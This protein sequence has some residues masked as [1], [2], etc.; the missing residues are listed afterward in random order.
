[1][2]QAIETYKKVLCVTTTKTIS[3]GTAHPYVKVALAFEG[4]VLK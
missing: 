3:S 4:H 2:K 1:M